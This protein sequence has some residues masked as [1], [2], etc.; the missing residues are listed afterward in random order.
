MSTSLPSST[1]PTVAPSH[2]EIAQYARELWAEAGQPES[3]DDEFWFGAE[4]RLLLARDVPN[5]SATILATLAQ[6]VTSTNI[7]KN[8]V[9]GKVRRKR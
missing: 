3:R 8:A 4:H 5:V 1:N 7:T 9:Q 2:D 6:P